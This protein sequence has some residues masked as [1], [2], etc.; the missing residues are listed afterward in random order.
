M[1]TRTASSSGAWTTATNWEAGAGPAPTNGDV[2]DLNGKT[3]SL[4]V[5]DI[6][7]DSIIGTGGGLT[8]TTNRT[9]TL[10]NAGT[11]ISGTW[12]CTLNTA[13]TTITIAAGTGTIV[14]STTAVTRFTVSG[15]STTLTITANL[16]GGSATNSRIV[17][18]TSG[19]VNI[20]GDLTGGSGANSEALRVTGGTGTVTGNATGGST[21]G[22]IALA[23]IVSGSS[24]ILN[25][26]G[27]VNG[28]SGTQGSANTMGN[29]GLGVYNT[30]T[31]NLTGS[32]VDSAKYTAVVNSGG[33][34]TYT[35]TAA[36]TATLGGKVLYNKPVRIVAMKA[37]KAA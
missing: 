7:V 33:V 14:G 22:I 28:G 30:G 24:S 26:T 17:N 23:A 1:A 27:T 21:N 2:A 4:D 6:N 25:F 5:S 11:V 12:T 10:T 37:N 3:M 13:S 16:T 32:V 35:P 31:L 20:T 15:S 19:A 8:C 29:H 34:F 36:Q 9:I 18:L